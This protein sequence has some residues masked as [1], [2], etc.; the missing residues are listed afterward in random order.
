M[1]QNDIPFDPDRPNC[2]MPEMP[3]CPACPHGIISYPEEI[4][5]GEGYFTDWN[6]A[7]DVPDP[8]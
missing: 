2:I 3:Y 4:I 1:N 6:C 7:L 5:P 8:M